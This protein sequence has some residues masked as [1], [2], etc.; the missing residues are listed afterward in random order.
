MSQNKYEEHVKVQAKCLHE[1][2]GITLK[3]IS[4][5]LEI[6]LSTI[7]GWKKTYNWCSRGKK[8]YIK[9]DWDTECFIK[10]SIRQGMT[11]KKMVSIYIDGMTNPTITINGV[12]QKDWNTILKYLTEFGI[13][14]GLR[15]R[16]KGSKPLVDIHNNNTHGIINFYLGDPNKKSKKVYIEGEVV[17]D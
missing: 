8:A 5:N 10:E 12:V 9:E 7:K 1:V 13:L 2:D 17:K 15:D 4:T 3:D 6:P 16:N 11:I 14:V